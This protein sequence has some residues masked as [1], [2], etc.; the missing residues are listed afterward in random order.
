MELTCYGTG[1]TGNCYIADLNGVK[2]M[3]D[4][5]V[6]LNKIPVNL[7][8]LSLAFVSHDHKDHSLEALN[9]ASKGVQ[10]LRH[11]LNQGFVKTPLW[12]K[13]GVDKQELVDLFT[14]DVK[15]GD[16]Y[17]AGL[18]IKTKTEQVLYITDFTVC[19]YSFSSI[20]FT[21][22][23]LECNYDD[24]SM[25]EALKKDNCF[26]YKRQFNTHMSTNGL[27]R[28]LSKLDLSNCNCIYLIHNSVGVGDPVK[29]AT[30]IS[31]KFNKKVGVC[32][33]R[34]GIDYYGGC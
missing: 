34:G 14:F 27:I 28:Y 8:N 10:V 24:E 23:I 32:L 31:C 33:Q 21:D 16:E 6:S 11:K 4:A 9:L 26:K 22:V 1:S 5:G 19:K 13:F 20:K 7:N 2:I 3:L 30:L 12:L 15:H 29:A 25:E 18:I 17:C